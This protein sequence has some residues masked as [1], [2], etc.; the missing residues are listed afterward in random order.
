MT[1]LQWENIALC[2]S[3]LIQ[4]SFPW[5]I[6]FDSGQRF[7]HVFHSLICFLCIVTIKT[8]FFS[9]FPSVSFF[10]L[11]TEIAVSSM[12]PLMQL[13]R[14]MS[15]LKVCFKVD[16]ELNLAQRLINLLHVFLHL[17]S[18]S[19]VALYVPLFSSNLRLFKTPSEF[20][21]VFYSS[22]VSPNMTSCLYS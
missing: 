2:F 17:H 5:K 20:F 4:R 11:S 6:S 12:L 18:F 19:R 15:S 1:S 14:N 8:F 21:I 7:C 3:F 9:F 10:P 16:R 13:H 22:T